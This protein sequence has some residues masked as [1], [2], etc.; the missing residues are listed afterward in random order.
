MPVV[1]DPRST[2]FLRLLRERLPEKRVSHSIFVAEYLSSFARQIGLDHDQAV[3]AGLLH[4]LCRTLS[5]D[6]MLQRAQ[7]Y[8][9]PVGPRQL[10]KPVLLH[11]PVAAEEVRRELGIDD[12]GIYEAIYWHTTGRP[13]LG[14]LG[15]ALY[16]ADFAEP[17]RP[18]AEAAQTRD[19]LRKV[20]FKDA[21]LF[22]THAKLHYVRKKNAD[23]PEGHAFYLWLQ[24][25]YA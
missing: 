7:E 14:K 20:G 3:A 2:E 13:E 4:D 22:A 19:M 6:E 10:A 11:G 8:D 9:L 5:N 21:M 23:N 24:Q 18:Y 16:L 15:Q 25:E 12:E 1:K 17:T